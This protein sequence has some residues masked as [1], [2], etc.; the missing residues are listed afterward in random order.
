[1][2]V[3]DENDI[4]EARKDAEAIVQQVKLNDAEVCREV[5]D[6]ARPRPPAKIPVDVV[7]LSRQMIV[8]LLPDA[9]KRNAKLILADDPPPRW[10]RGDS[11]KLMQIFTNLIINAAQ[12]MP[13]GGV[14]T[15]SVVAKSS[16]AAC[17]SGRAA[18]K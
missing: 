15:L 3:T 11:S 14:V 7:Q 8:L 17:G 2:I 13:R 9:R 18:R 1:M 10:V 16:A 4:A 5:L 6:Y 12:A